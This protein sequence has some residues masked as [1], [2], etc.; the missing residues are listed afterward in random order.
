MTLM[1]QFVLSS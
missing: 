1:H